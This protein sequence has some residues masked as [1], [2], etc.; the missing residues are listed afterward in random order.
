MA[1]KDSN[2]DLQGLFDSMQTA[3]AAPAAVSEILEFLNCDQDDQFII[4]GIVSKQA[5]HS[6][7]AGLRQLSE[8]LNCSES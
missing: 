3:L 8:S 6:V 4:E 1:K 2:L 7:S 5:V